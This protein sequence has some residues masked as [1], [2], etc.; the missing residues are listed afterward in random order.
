MSRLA[1]EIRTIPRS[2]QI[3]PVKNTVTLGLIAKSMKITKGIRYVGK[4]HAP[5]RPEV[6]KNNEYM[7]E[8]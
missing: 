5:S 2:S 6:K 1:S 7:I 3:I 4:I 8:K